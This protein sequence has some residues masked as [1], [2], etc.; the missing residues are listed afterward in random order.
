MGLS[1]TNREISRVFYHKDRN[2]DLLPGQLPFL[3]F[4]TRT[5]LT[6]E[7][8]LNIGKS[9]Y[10]TE[11]ALDDLFIAESGKAL[12]SPQKLIKQG[13]LGVYFPGTGEVWLYTPINAVKVVDKFTDINWQS[14]QTYSGETLVDYLNTEVLKP[15]GKIIDDFNLRNISE[16]E[17][18]SN[19][20]SVI[21]Q[22]KNGELDSDTAYEE[23]LKNLN[24]LTI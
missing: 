19:V 5:S 23:F 12:P 6:I 4:Y 13:K 3:T 22:V 2:A 16:L 11:I 24:P 15:T 7:P 10:R 21:Q 17:N 1:K 8:H 20:S 14:K 9:L 18:A